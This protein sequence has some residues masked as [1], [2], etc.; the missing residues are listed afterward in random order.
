MPISRDSDLLLL[1]YIRWFKCTTELRTIH[2]FLD[3]PDLKVLILL[4]SWYEKGTDPA[5]HFCQSKLRMKKKQ[6][7]KNYND[8]LLWWSN[9]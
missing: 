9:G 6:K 1:R 8:R 3:H 7:Q 4:G 2:A 5:G